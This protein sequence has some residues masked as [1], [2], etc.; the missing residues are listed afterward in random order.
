[1]FFHTSPTRRR[2]RRWAIALSGVTLV[3]AGLAAAPLVLSHGEQIA[4]GGGEKGPV[5]LTAAQEKTLGVKV[6]AA[7]LRPLA[8]LLYLNGEVQLV[9]GRQA[10]ASPRI[11]GQVTALYVNLGDMVK[12]GQRLARIQSRLVGNPPPSVDITAPRSGVVDAVDVAVG[13]AV[14]PAT[15]L[16]RI[17]DRS[18]V[19]V[20]AQVYEEDLGKVRLGQ[21]AT[22]HTL[23]Y[24]DRPFV[25]KIVLVGP[26][27][28]PQSR[29]VDVW[30]RLANVDGS[31]K[32]NLFARASVVLRQ[33]NAMLTV[34]NAA[35]IAANG[36]KFVF[37]RQKSEYTRVEITTGADDERFTEVTNGLVPGDEVVTQGNRE[38]Y[39]LWLT[40][41]AIKSEDD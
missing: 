13:Q 29:T 7:D 28:D 10:D 34:P 6:V 22:V 9:P 24:P 26:T 15:S 19:N 25:G 31:L 37:V 35:I 39:T 3:F 20:V 2:P 41:G 4:V 1:M 27:L 8:E 21:D 36:E 38:I 11:S 33:N 12:A 16:V 32:P 30:I 14:E 18:E 5:H 17:S 23:S 40:G